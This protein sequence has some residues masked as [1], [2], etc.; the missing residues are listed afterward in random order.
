MLKFSLKGASW[1]TLTNQPPAFM[2]F[3]VHLWVFPSL[4]LY[5]LPCSFSRYFAWIW[6]KNIRENSLKLKLVTSTLKVAILSPPLSPSLTG[7]FL[8]YLFPVVQAPISLSPST[9]K[10][11]RENG[12]VLLLYNIDM[13]KS[14][15]SFP[16]GFRPS[17]SHLFNKVSLT[18]NHLL[19]AWNPLIPAH[20][21]ATTVISVL[22]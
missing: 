7:S 6:G 15:H 16:S 19:L 11:P 14:E 22:K 4:R 13:F 8:V 12:K 21:E 2:V 5:P 3:S 1:S 18:K 10:P 17:F 20:R 9:H